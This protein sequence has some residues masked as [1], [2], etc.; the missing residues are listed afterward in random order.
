[1]LTRHTLPLMIILYFF[2]TGK[3]DGQIIWVDNG[4]N[5]ELIKPLQV[6]SSRNDEREIKIIMPSIG[7]RSVC[8]DTVTIAGLPVVSVADGDCTANEHS[9]FVVN[10]LCIGITSFQVPVMERDTLCFEL[11]NADDGCIKFRILLEIR[12]PLR[13]PFFEDFAYSGPYPDSIKWLDRNVFINQSLSFNPLSIGVATF[14]GLNSEGNAYGIGR[15]RADFLTSSFFD[16][17]TFNQ[18]DDVYLS[19][20]TQPKGLGPRPRE[21]DS[22]VLEFRHRD[23]SWRKVTDYTGLPDNYPIRNSPD[24]TFRRILLTQ[25]YL[26]RSFQFRFVNINSNTGMTELW[27]LDYIRL[28]HG[29]VPS[30]AHTDIAFT[31]VPASF[32]KPYS[33]MPMV[34]FEAD[35][36]KYI[37]DALPIGL[38]NHFNSLAIAEPSRFILREQI[39]NYTISDDLTLLEVPPVVPQNQR[40]LAPGRH[41]FSNPLRTDTWLNSFLSW[42]RGKDSLRIETTYSFEQDQERNAG[43][44]EL[45]RNNIVKRLT[46]ISDYY[47]YD[48]GTAELGLAVRSSPGIFSELVVRYTA[49]KG[50]YLNALYFNFPRLDVDIRQQIFNIKVYIGN[51]KDTADYTDILKRPVYADVYNPGL[52]GFSW[53]PVLDEET[54]ESSTIFI[55]PGDFYVGLQQVNVTD[56]PIPV[57][58]DR[59]S[60]LGTDHIFVK[61]SGNWQS[62]A[63][64]PNR[65]DGSLMIRAVIKEEDV[66]RADDKVVHHKL[67]VYPNPGSGLIFIKGVENYEKAR[68]R[69]FDLTGTCVY[70]NMIKAE[71]DVHNL[72]GGMYLLHIADLNGV[73]L[74]SEKLIIH[75]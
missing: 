17:S 2:L 62:F 60:P 70:S 68:I 40:N 4:Y 47:A 34:Q 51:L 44:P 58:F 18:A 14:D 66:V 73:L 25:D 56:N 69:I 5:P 27:H 43:V 31:A 7:T 59:N 16:L 19:F 54:L 49:E 15:A 37:N 65:I 46:T 29:F 20:Y 39:E 1:M 67:S 71:N 72:P 12:R 64:Q 57:G 41:Q 11:C 61:L 36:E 74:H 53:Y 50:G 22:L 3:T 33:A 35:K 75:K 48:D 24:F 9:D 8:F 26:H 23:G 32:L 63:S 13:I 10:A 21:A 55:P 52:N 45:L 28:T 38:Y 42:S 30:G 6:V